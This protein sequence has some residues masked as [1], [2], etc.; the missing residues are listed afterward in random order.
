MNVI[1]HP[2]SNCRSRRA[3]A[4]GMFDG[5]HLG[6]MEI[7]RCL[8]EEALKRGL[9]AAVITFRNHPQLFFRKES[10]LKMIM[11]LDERLAKLSDMGIKTTIL[12]DF[13]KPLSKLSAYDFIKKIRDEF[14]VRLLIIGFNHRFG[15]NK[16]DNFYDYCEYGLQLGVEIIQGK[17]YDGIY[18]PVSSSIIRKLISAGKVDDAMNCLGHPFTLKGEVVHGFKRG[19][20]IGYPTAN[21]LPQSNSIIIPHNGVYAIN[22]VMEGGKKYGGMVNIGTRPTF[23]S[24]KVISIEANIFDFSGDIYGQNLTLEFVKFLRSEMK[25]ESVEML[26]KQLK[27]D[28]DNARHILNNIEI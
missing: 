18:C 12:F 27:T 6:H 28:E 21:I 17:E 19:R 10:D 24:E 3:A 8:K 15:H 1:E 20:E 4:I 14:G 11:S 23:T 7:I 5:V 13:D 2:E 25:M 16:S 26:K 9:E 22:I